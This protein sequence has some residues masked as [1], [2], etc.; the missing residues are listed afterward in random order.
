MQKRFAGMMTGTALAVLSLSALTASV[1]LL[2]PLPALAGPGNSGDHGGGNSGNH[3]GGNSG[4]GGGNSGGGNASGSSG[5]GASH[6]GGAAGNGS[7]HSELKGL[8]A[9]HASLTAM[10]NAAPT[11]QVG[12]LAAYRTAALATQ[13]DA[14]TLAAA[15]AAYAA[16]VG[17]YTG[18]SATDLAAQ[19]AAADTA[20]AALQS[21]IDALD[22]TSPTYAAD[23]A[24]LQG[25]MTDTSQLSAEL[26]QA[27]TY[28]TDL[29]QLQATVDAAQTSYSTDQASEQT[30]LDTATGGRTL[31]DA[32]LAEL[33][34]ELG[35]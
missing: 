13:T 5:G 24:A 22:P 26:Q 31:S 34:S 30:A 23:A 8:N 1:Y 10:A 25:Q 4:G 29:A 21:Q 3:G 19:I 35:L 2:A 11:S 14:Q 16:L 15:Q 7:V 18:P 27:Q 12:R 32:A 33:R 28:E 17:T 9:A 6:A 20:N